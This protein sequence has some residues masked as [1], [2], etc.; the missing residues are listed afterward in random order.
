[1]FFSLSYTGA[2]VATSVEWTFVPIAARDFS[3]IVA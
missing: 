2:A 1:M 3:N